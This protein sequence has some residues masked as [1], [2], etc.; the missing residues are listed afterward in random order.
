[1]G[2][3]FAKGED[4]TTPR[5]AAGVVEYYYH[6]Y[7]KDY[8]TQC[9]Q[10]TELGTKLKV[11]DVQKDGEAPLFD[12]KGRGN[13]KFLNF[14][15][16]CLWTPGKARAEARYVRPD[17]LVGEFITKTEKGHCRDA[18]QDP[19]YGNGAGCSSMRECR[20][21]L[22]WVDSAI[23]YR[24]HKPNDPVGHTLGHITRAYL[25]EHVEQ[26]N[27]EPVTAEKFSKATQRTRRRL[28]H[29]DLLRRL[30]GIH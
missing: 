15:R 24:H 27:L 28:A 12:E 18:T 17:V 16:E 6:D 13:P 1:M 21:K 7:Y 14:Q 26:A 25:K 10:Q 11:T 2:G 8:S 4:I 20:K 23:L 22:C 30:Q 5:S 9:P 3:R 29:A 19:E